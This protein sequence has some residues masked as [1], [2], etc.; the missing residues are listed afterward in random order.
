MQ[1]VSSDV[2]RPYLRR[3]FP[4]ATEEDLDAAIFRS[5]GFV[6]Q[7]EEYLQSGDRLPAQTE[8]FL[9]A[10][11]GRDALL[12][13]EVLV[14]MEKWKRDQ[15]LEILESWLEILESALACR[16]GIQAVSAPARQLAAQR[17]GEELYAAAVQLK[18][19]LDYGRGNVSAA[20]ICGYL[21]WH[22]R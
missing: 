11:G 10:F 20:A 15:L 14:P 8:D 1:A 5:G 7:A 22:L 12:L 4:Q 3:A 16:S 21:Q 18:K 6:G 2:L 17:T 9:R 13:T 19:A